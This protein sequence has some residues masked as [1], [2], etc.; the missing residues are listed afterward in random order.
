MEAPDELVGEDAL[1][2]ENAG[3][4][5]V[6]VLDPSAL[7]LLR[8]ESKLRAKAIAAPPPRLSEARKR[9]A[10]TARLPPPSK[11]P[12]PGF[13]STTS[14]GRGV[15]DFM[16]ARVAQRERLKAARAETEDAKDAKDANAEVTTR[17]RAEPLDAGAGPDVDDLVDSRTD[18][19]GVPAEEPSRTLDDVEP[20]DVG[21]DVPVAYE[22]TRFET[23]HEADRARMRDAL[24]RRE[25]GA[26]APPAPASG[27]D[28]DVSGRA[29][30]SAS[31]ESAGLPRPPGSAPGGSRDAGASRVATP[32]R[33]AARRRR[34]ASVSAVW[35]PATTRTF[36]DPITGTPRWVFP[37]SFPPRRRTTWWTS[38]TSRSAA[39]TAAGS[40]CRTW[41]T[42]TR[43]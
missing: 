7:E 33:D 17:L 39:R 34:A 4:S 20:D 42:N 6:T 29:L 37:R 36:S 14:T 40:G 31:R 27:A 21:I 25:R 38:G 10:E 28:A 32:T 22:P 5:E 30:E 24:L 16:K 12:R 13:M 19:L 11:P 41:V 2:S 3:G 23:A 18:D 43:R 9:E 35:T 8:E 15:R 1:S 26:G